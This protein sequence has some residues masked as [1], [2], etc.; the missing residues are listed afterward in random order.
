MRNWGLTVF[1]FIIVFGSLSTHAQAPK[2]NKSAALS[3][4]EPP[5]AK[6]WKDSKEALNKLAEK[7][8]DPKLSKEQ[9]VAFL[10]AANNLL[11]DTQ[12]LKLSKSERKEQIAVI[13][14]FIAATIDTDF[15]NSNTDSTYDHFKANKK[16]YLAEIAKI[17]NKDTREEIIDAYDSW[18]EAEKD[19]GKK[20]VD[21]EA[22]TM[23]EA[24]Y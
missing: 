13:V 24:E 20:D 5:V 15:A 22:G 2:A 6:T 21:E 19:A 18:A 3:A 1:A 4:P 23:P 7:F 16:A 17:D 11:Y 12:Q 10:P 14:Q 9:K 8:R